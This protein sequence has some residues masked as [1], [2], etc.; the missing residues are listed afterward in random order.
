MAT[1]LAAAA[2]AAG[3]P[4]PSLCSSALMPVIIV[5]AAGPLASGRR[6]KWA[7]E[8][9]VGSVCHKLLLTAGIHTL[10]SPA[11]RMVAN[12]RLRARQGC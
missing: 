6:G 11:S 8:P 2:V 9:G 7:A 5:R 1:P 10:R 4:P 12:N 3:L